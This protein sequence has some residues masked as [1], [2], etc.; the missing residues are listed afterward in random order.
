VTRPTRPA[1]IVAA[2]L[3]TTVGAALVAGLVLLLTG[4]VALDD[5][6]TTIMVEILVI[7][8]LIS[9]GLVAY[10]SHDHHDHNHDD[11]GQQ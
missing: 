1:G 2:I 11:E 5:A 7:I 3:A 6:S 4:T 10:V 9:G 8:G